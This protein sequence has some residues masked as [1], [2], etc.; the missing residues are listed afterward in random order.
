MEEVL[1]RVL[2]DEDLGYILEVDLEYPSELHDLHNDYPLAPEPMKIN[3]VN[4]LVPNLRNKTKYILHHRNL[5][6]YLSLGLRLTKIHRIIEFKQSKWL[7]PYITL[8]TNLRTE[9]KNNFE[10]DFFKLMNNSVFG[11]TMENIRNRKD[12]KLVT[13]KQQALKLI[14]KPNFKHRTIFT[15]NLI[16]VHMSKTKL[17]FNKPVYVGMCILD[18]SKVL[19]YDFHYNYI[20]PK[21]NEHALLLMTDTDSLCYEIETEDFYKDIAGDVESKFDT[22]AYPKEHPS[23]IKTGVNKKVIGMMKDECSGEVMVGFVGL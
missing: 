10:K 9:A 2:L 20:K 23:G 7:A 3:K 1:S 5:G 18:V 13:S 17:V 21:Y 12:I 15:E 11:K 16:S 19:M 14:A 8:N 22:S 4:K 6:L